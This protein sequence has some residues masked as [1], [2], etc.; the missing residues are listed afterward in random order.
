MIYMYYNSNYKNDY[1]IVNNNTKLRTYKVSE[2]A[3]IILLK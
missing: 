3:I 1:Y 2:D